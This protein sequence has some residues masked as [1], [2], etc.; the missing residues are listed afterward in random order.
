MICLVP[1]EKAPSPFQFFSLQIRTYRYL[2]PL[3]TGLCITTQVCRTSSD[4]QS[5]GDYWGR[6]LKDQIINLKSQNG[7]NVYFTGTDFL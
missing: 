6:A 1:G 7:L 5:I 3:R 2:V 4:S